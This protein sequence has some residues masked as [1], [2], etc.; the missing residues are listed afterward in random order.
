MSVIPSGFGEASV[1]IGIPGD[2]GPAY[3]IF[4]Y[5]FP[6]G[7]SPQANAN[8][9]AGILATTPGFR[10]LTSSTN[11]IRQVVVRE[12]YAGPFLFIANATI[13]A[14]GTLA[15]AAPSPQVSYLLRKST[16]LAG[17]QNRGRMYVPAANEDEIDAGGFLSAPAVADRQAS[18][19][20]FFNA[21]VSASL[22]MYILHTDPALSPTEV[23][24]LEV[25]GKVA[26]QRRRLR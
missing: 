10:S 4:G 19:D 20:L 26:T 11:N 16:G 6:G 22:P 9:L 8:T 5:Q 25:D 18:A 23:D 13:N 7:G 12:N 15:G 3:V 14:F 1:E 17:R 2:A 21:L 24:S